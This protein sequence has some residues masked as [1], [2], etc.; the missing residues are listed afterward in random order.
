MNGSRSNDLHADCVESRRL[1]EECVFRLIPATDPL[2]PM[3][4]KRLRDG[5]S[6]SR[7]SLIC[8]L[9]SL[10]MEDQQWIEQTK[11]EGFNEKPLSPTSSALIREST[12]NYLVARKRLSDAL[13]RSLVASPLNTALGQHLSKSDAFNIPPGYSL[14][15]YQ[16]SVGPREP[17]HPS[18][19]SPS[20][21]GLRD[22]NP[23][24]LGRLQITLPAT[25]NR[26]FLDDQPIYPN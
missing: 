8:L 11:K 14:V 17:V 13:R 21:V 19:S 23:S 22:V 2:V 18:T 7:D 26:I 24:D 4:E 25:P 16:V 5:P 10:S 3:D 15:L 9:R 20:S 12:L 1:C 6:R